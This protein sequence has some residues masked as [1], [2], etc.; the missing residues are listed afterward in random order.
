MTK[1]FPGLKLALVSAFPPGRQSLNEYG[2]HLAK[3]FAERSDVAEVVVLADRLATP[4]AELDLGPK[5]RVRRIWAFNSPT[6]VLSITS[7]LMRERVDGVLF[8]VQTATFG[9]WELPAALGLFAPAMARFTGT[10]SGVLA[11]NLIGGIDLEST[12]L[13]GQRLRQALI[14]AGG[15]VVTRALLSANYLAVTLEGYRKMVAERYPNAE[16]TLIPHGTFDTSRRDTLS[17]AERPMR[18]VTMGKF[19]T[20]KRLEALLRA[21]D[22]LKEHGDFPDLELVIGG[23]D[24]PSTPGYMERIAKKTAGDDRIR[25]AGY[26]PEDDIPEFFGTARVSVFDYDSTTG[27]SGV[28]H[29]TASYGAVPVFPRIGDFVDV[30]RD[31]GLGG[32]HYAPGDAEGMATAIASILRDQSLADG[33]ADANREA[34]LGI[35]FSQVIASHVERFSALQGKSG[36]Q[37]MPIG[38]I[39]AG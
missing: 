24:H 18:I 26:L 36:R 31:E 39:P 11:H 6:A 25:F 9:D 35:P 19:G 21:F 5:I 27:S 23:A 8:N 15:R 30:C 20:Y 10:P 37:T 33:L 14:S 12:Q 7:A 4:V 3:G 17:S 13:R 29:Q 22:L 28:L 34:S 16:V 38:E 2:L 32:V 1:D